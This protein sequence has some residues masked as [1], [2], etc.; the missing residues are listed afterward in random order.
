ML[1]VEDGTGLP[2]ADSYVGVGEADAILLAEVGNESW[3]E[4]A[5]EDRERALRTATRVID[6]T[7]RWLGVPTTTTQALA[8]PRMYAMRPDGSGGEIAS[9]EIPTALKVAVTYFAAR[10]L[11]EPTYLHDLDDAGVAAKSAGGTSRSYRTQQQ[12]EILPAAVRLA[13]RRLAAGRTIPMV[14]LT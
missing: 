8:W 4:S 12:T 13:L 1:T 10:L 9:D 5:A 7:Q 11:Q 3:P 2:D 6:M 14:R